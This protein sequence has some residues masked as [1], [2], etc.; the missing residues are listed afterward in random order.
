MGRESFLDCG[1][2]NRPVP[3]VVMAMAFLTLVSFVIPDERARDVLSHV[4]A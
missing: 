4:L 2:A 1:Y 3:C